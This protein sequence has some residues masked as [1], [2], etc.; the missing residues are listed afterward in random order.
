MTHL[1]NLGSQFSQPL[2]S[3]KLESL[4]PIEEL[5]PTRSTV[6]VPLNLKSIEAVTT[7]WLLW[8]PHASEL[9]EHQKQQGVIVLIRSLTDHDYY[10]PMLPPARK[11]FRTQGPGVQGIYLANS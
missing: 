3:A 1:W 8:D 10:S 9:A 2:G 7:T 4:V 6:R 11:M 5:F